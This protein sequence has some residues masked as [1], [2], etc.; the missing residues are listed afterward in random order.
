MAGTKEGGRKAAATVK[1]RHGNDFYAR[2][3]SEGGK[4]GH[5]GG[6]YNQSK[7][8]KLAGLKGGTVSS[9]GKKLTKKELAERRE[10]AEKRYEMKLAELEEECDD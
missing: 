10:L 6:F 8:A 7:R 2:I 5:T 3:G 9:R 1:S 4:K